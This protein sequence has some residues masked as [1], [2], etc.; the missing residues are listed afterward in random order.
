MRAHTN[1][2]FQ[3]NYWTPRCRCEI[4]HFLS[5]HFDKLHKLIARLFVF[6]SFFRRLILIDDQIR[7]SEG[8]FNVHYFIGI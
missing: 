1:T 7:R 4:F 2:M 6:L 8:H 3:C 5:P